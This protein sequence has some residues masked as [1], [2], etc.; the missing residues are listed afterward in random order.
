MHLQTL[1]LPLLTTLQ[2][3][4]TS[5]SKP[6]PPKP[7]TLWATHYNGNVYTLTLT[8][9]HD[10]SVT[11]TLKT[12]GKMPSWLTLDAH[13]RT[14]YCSDE[15]GTTDPSTHG[16]LTALAISANGSLSEI[17]KADTIGGGVASVLY[18]GDKGGE[19]LAIAH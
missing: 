18:G 17:A 14:V 5:A 16:S 4:P 1:L 10:L 19:Y 13:S 15:D 3:T 12:C 9:E 7:S 6:N 11:Q 8:P 2:I